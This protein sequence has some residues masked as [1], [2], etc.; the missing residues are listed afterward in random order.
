MP[1]SG[2]KFYTLFPMG[3]DRSSENFVKI[4]N[5]V[6]LCSAVVGCIF[7]VNIVS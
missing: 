7:A 5:I 6:V 1:L 2:N 3:S 4:M